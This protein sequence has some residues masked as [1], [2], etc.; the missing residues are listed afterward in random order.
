M[1]V[2]LTPRHRMP[3]SCQ[4]PPSPFFYAYPRSH[5]LPNIR[6]AWHLRIS[7]TPSPVKR[8]SPSFGNALFRYSTT[9]ATEG[10]RTPT[11]QMPLTLSVYRQ[12]A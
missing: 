11:P 2:F 1:P 10:T 9:K 7:D 12:A 4:R 3:T 6:P 5:I 8:M